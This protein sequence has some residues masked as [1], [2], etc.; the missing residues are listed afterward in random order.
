MQQNNTTFEVSLLQ[1]LFFSF[2]KWFNSLEVALQTL[3]ACELKVSGEMSFIQYCTN[4][5][6]FKLYFF[7]AQDNYFWLQSQYLYLYY[8]IYIL[9][10]LEFFLFKIQLDD[11][12]LVDDDVGFFQNIFM[13]FSFSHICSGTI[14]QTIMLESAYSILFTKFCLY[15]LCPPLPSMPHLQ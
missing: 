6:M 5:N 15:I 14:I 7:S 11:N 10:I 1:T 12:T 4:R 2:S 3:H 9:H 8:V 13:L